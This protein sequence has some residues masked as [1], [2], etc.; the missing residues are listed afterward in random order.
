MD[1]MTYTETPIKASKAKNVKATAKKNT[2]KALDELGGFAL[3]W[4]VFKRLVR[5]L[6]VNKVPLTVNAFLIENFYL[7]NQHFGLF[8][9]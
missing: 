7:L 4:L 3:T 1:G 8:F 2:A 5:F 9:K 6:W